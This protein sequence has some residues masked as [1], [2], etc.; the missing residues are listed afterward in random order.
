MTHF[1]K[2]TE[3]S[4]SLLL[5]YD[6]KA[7]LLVKYVNLKE[8]GAEIEEGVHIRKVILVTQNKYNCIIDK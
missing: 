6:I 5:L 1:P 3:N 2:Q 7:Q 8:I 4:K